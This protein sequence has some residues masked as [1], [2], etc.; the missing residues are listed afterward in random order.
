MKE[1]KDEKL[2]NTDLEKMWGGDGP[3]SQVS[4]HEQINI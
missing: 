4:L 3:Y 1:K 2:T